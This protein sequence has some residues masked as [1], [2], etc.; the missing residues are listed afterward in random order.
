MGH[1]T[2][3]VVVV[4]V[5]DSR[6]RQVTFAV[7]LSESYD[8]VTMAVSLMSV[9]RRESSSVDVPSRSLSRLFDH[10]T[11]RRRVSFL[12]VWLWCCRVWSLARPFAAARQPRSQ[13]VGEQQQQRHWEHE[14]VRGSATWWTF[15]ATCA[16]MYVPP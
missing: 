11:E 14:S 8:D 5:V 16:E 1:K 9:W 4:V 12:G 7:L 15:C 3:V 10:V 2:V 13:S 6:V